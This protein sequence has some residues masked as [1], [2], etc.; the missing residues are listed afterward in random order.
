M[1]DKFTLTDSQQRALDNFRIFVN[2]MNSK[3]FILRGYAGTGKT[4]LVRIFIQELHKDNLSFHLLASTGRA[5]KILSN[6]T[7]MTATTV[8]SLIYKFRDLNQNLEEAAKSREKQKIDTSGQLYLDF[9]LGYAED[10]GEEHYYLIDEASMISDELDK[11]IEQA[12]FGSGKLLEDL[13]KYDRN[14]KFIFIGDSCQLPPV[15]QKISPALSIEHFRKEYS[16]DAAQSELTE[17]VRQ[18]HGNDITTAASKI[19]DQFFHPQTTTAATFNL[20]GYNNIKIVNTQIELINKYIEITQKVGFENSSIICFSNSISNKLTKIIRPSFGHV[21]SQLE[22]GDLLLVTQNNMPTGLM[23]GDLVVVDNI[24]VRRK[25]AN[26]TFLPVSIK[27]LYTNSNYELLLIEELLYSNH[28]NLHP[29]Q[30]KDLFIDF[31]YRMDEKGIKQGTDRFLHCMRKDEYLNALR[32]VFG[33]ALTC[34]KSQGGE[35]N[36]VFLDIP[37]NLPYIEK[38]YVYQW[39]YTAVTRAKQEL[40]IVDDYWVKPD[41]SPIRKWET[42][43][44]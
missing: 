24:G 10:N 11:N 7:G 20:R 25:R 40:Y 14:G 18:E 43:N 28:T 27:E 4:T 17:I 37:R 8:H 30:L 2:S 19:R 31:Y 15:L 1:P 32:T 22:K 35:W 33:Y 39:L 3:I 21:S 6:A 41:K 29:E 36:Y 23:N 5:A 16:E 44:L 26:L 38:P 42:I 13:L 34:H 9:E 12:K